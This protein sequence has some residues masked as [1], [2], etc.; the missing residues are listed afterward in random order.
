MDNESENPN[1]Q[2][3]VSKE[4]SEQMPLTTENLAT[5]NSERNESHDSGSSNDNQN[6][7][8]GQAHPTLD[9]IGSQFGNDIA[10]T[11]DEGN[12]QHDDTPMQRWKSTSDDRPLFWT[13][14]EEKKRE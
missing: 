1:V 14:D 5:H 12:L 9:D 11:T 2:H 7:D 3:Q 4:S 13:P 8:Q 6:S 10:A